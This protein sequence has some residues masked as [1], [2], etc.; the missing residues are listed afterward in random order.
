VAERLSKVTAHSRNNAEMSP[1][2]AGSMRWIHNVLD[3]PTLYHRFSNEV[4]SGGVSSVD[5]FIIQQLNAGAHD[6][7]QKRDMPRCRRVEMLS[8]GYIGLVED[9][10]RPSER[11]IVDNYLGMVGLDTFEGER[12]DTTLVD[13]AALSRMMGMD[14]GERAPDLQS[15]GFDLASRPAPIKGE[16]R[17]AAANIIDGPSPAVAHAAPRSAGFILELLITPLPRGATAREEVFC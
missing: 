7:R 11:R 8:I 2:M 13:L 3:L 5:Y 15:M 9:R 10:L 1:R 17:P 14:M 16:A 4:L 12:T 6:A